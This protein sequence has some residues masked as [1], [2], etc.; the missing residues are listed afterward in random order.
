MVKRIAIVGLGTVG[1]AVV[2][3]INKY[4]STIFRRTGLK[5]N[6]SWLC[7]LNRSKK[8]VAQ[9]C[10]LPFSSNPE[11]VISDDK[12]DIL[13]ELIGGV[14]PAFTYI[15]AALE[16]GKD[17]VTANKALLAQC[18]K[19]LFPL[20]QSK[21]KSIGF[22]ASVCGA[23]PL[24]KSISEGLIGC[25]V[26]KLYG[27]V[28]GT[29]NYILDHMEKEEKDFAVILKD[30]QNKGL[31][32]KNPKLDIDGVDSLHKLCILSY[33]C[34]GVWP[35][36]KDVYTQG[37]SKI[38]LLDISYAKEMNYRIKLLAMAKRLA[39]GIEL[40][41]QPTLLEQD[42]PLAQVDEAYNAVYLNAQP[43]GDLLFFGQGAGG[44]PTSSAVISDIV[45]IA[46]G[47]A[48]LARAKEKVSLLN[49]ND[50]VARYYI[51][52]N[53]YDKPGV[54]AQVAQILSSH[55]ISIASVTQKQQKKGKVVPIVMIT[56]QAKEANIK[57][58]L[59]LIDQLKVVKSPTQHIRIEN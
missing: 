10:S 37:I 51:R 18:G 53:A 34:F 5:L 2:N 33:L 36:F 6:I 8:S 24:I 56:H 46:L 26:K 38:S 14:E 13:V 50:I 29:T 47:Q 4:S 15:K 58:A 1:Q 43:A 32:E 9:K 52:F 45:R 3:S 21:N 41:V 27:I 12:V 31:A 44:V 40:S 16:K 48:N 55:K 30:A 7:D 23:I 19:E 17:V 25:Q 39:K 11:E 59:L 54:L 22:E 20:A 28:N 49:S 35:V 42:H 57:E